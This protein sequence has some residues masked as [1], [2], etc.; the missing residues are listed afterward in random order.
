M[1]P[2]SP[3]P[4]S[5]S[6]AGVAYISENLIKRLSKEENLANIK[7]LNLALGKDLNK[8]FRYLENLDNL[9]NLSALHIS[10]HMIEKIEKLD[11][12]TQ[13]RELNLSRN[14]IT[15]LEGLE[16]LVHLQVLNISRNQIQT[17]PAPLMKKLRELRVF[18]FAYNSLESVS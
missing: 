7:S 10:N 17:L 15:K 16:S 13:L 2:T 4:T 11:K 14:S 3:S 9:K 6:K 1:S 12:L 8:K 18:H 5:P